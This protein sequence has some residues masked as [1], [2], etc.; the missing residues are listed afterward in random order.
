MRFLNKAQKPG[1]QEQEDEESHGNR[2]EEERE[3]DQVAEKSSEEEEEDDEIEGSGG[4][5]DRYTLCFILNVDEVSA[6]VFRHGPFSSQKK[7]LLY[8]LGL[9]KTEIF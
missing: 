4:R 9:E 6:F 8:Q 5:L 7:L 2:R 3:S 1:L